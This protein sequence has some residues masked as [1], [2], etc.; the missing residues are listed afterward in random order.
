MRFR[1][2]I[3][4]NDLHVSRALVPSR[5]RLKEFYIRVSNCTSGRLRGS[6]PQPKTALLGRA[7]PDRGTNADRRQIKGLS[8]EPPVY[9]FIQR[10]LGF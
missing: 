7:L 1:A 5:G 8:V 6:E 9:Y 2:A 4:H 10:L 3:P